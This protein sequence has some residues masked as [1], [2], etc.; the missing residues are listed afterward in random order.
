MEGLLSTVSNTQKA[1]N[2]V[3]TNTGA[4][5]A[6]VA[7]NTQKAANNLFKNIPVINSLNL[8]R[9]SANNG[10]NSLFMNVGEATTSAVEN[11]GSVA[12]SVVSNI[13]N[14]ATSARNN[15]A[16]TGFKWVNPLTIVIAFVV[17]F[18]IVFS[19]YS[20]E[21]KIGWDT[22][23]REVKKLFR[24]GNPTQP[25][26]EITSTPIAPQDEI[27]MPTPPV[28]KIVENVL[29][30]KGLGGDKQVFNVEANDYTYYDAEP[31]CRALGAELATY[32]Q[33]KEAWDRGADWCN[34]GWVKGQMAIYP[35]QQ[36]TYDKLQRGP[37]DQRGAC[38][39]PGINGGVFDNP[40]MR[41]GVNC[42]G[43]KPA[44]DDDSAIRITQQGAIP[45]TVDY[46][47]FDEKVNEFKKDPQSDDVLP[48]N[49]EKWS[50][51]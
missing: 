39:S 25:S 20:K 42:F 15:I 5:F 19:V 17:L 1:L 32:D 38:G 26:R 16:P 10:F 47:K 31:L 46:L 6:T 2:T 13:G 30:I 14:I 41:F 44:Q 8:V 27:A 40:E 37:A 22:L 29:P 43:K 3:A 28:E 36:G 12:T 24:R 33:V 7:T 11:I 51:A 21:I 49:S 4:A 50:Q 23:V 48:F 18:L 35:T 34:Y 45:K 9:P